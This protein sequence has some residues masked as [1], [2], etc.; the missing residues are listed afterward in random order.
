MSGSEQPQSE[1]EA[2]LEALQTLVLNNALL[3]EPQLL[4][5]REQAS[6]LGAALPL[7]HAS[8]L[9]VGCAFYQG[10]YHK[11]LNYAEEGLQLSHLHHLPLF[12]AWALSSMGLANQRLGDLSR[13][14]HFLLE[15]LKVAEQ[16]NDQLGC[17]RAMLNIGVV[18]D[19]LG[20]HD[21][22]LALHEQA[23]DAARACG[24]E[25][26]FIADA[27]YSRLEDHYKL[28][29]YA[30][31]L[32]LSAEVLAFVHEHHFSRFECNTRAVVAQ[33]LVAMGRNEAALQSV[34]A[35][36]V[37]AQ[38]C[39]D[40]ESICRLN[41]I[42][43]QILLEQGQIQKAQQVLTE[44]LRLSQ[45]LQHKS[46]ERQASA[47]LARVYEKQQQFEQAYRSLRREHELLIEQT[48]IEATWRTQQLVSKANIELNRSP[49]ITSLKE[50]GAAVAPAPPSEYVRPNVR[51]TLTGAVNRPY[52]QSRVQK[53]LELLAPEEH[54]GLLFVS[55][56]HMRSINESY[57]P[58]AGDSV[59]VEMARRLQENVRAGDLVGRVS[60]DEF[61]LLLGNLA[62]PEDLQLVMDKLL[63]VL[64]QPI[65]IAEQEF[66]ITASLGG[67]VAPED[68]QNIETLYRHADLALQQVKQTGRNAGVRFQPYMSAEEEQRRKLEF[69]LR[70]AA[71]RGEL[72]L[73][74][75]AQYDLP[76][77]RLVGYEALVRWQHP[78]LGLLG[79]GTFIPMAE[80]SHLI[81]EIG[82]WV[83]TEACRQAALWDF[84]GRDLV[85]SV[86]VSAMQFE[87]PNF[88]QRV[89]SVLEQFQLNG[90]NLA[91]ELTE[92]MVQRNQKHAVISIQEL[93]EIGVQV[94][95]DDFG[96]GYSSLS[97]LQTLPFATLKI[98]RSF[99][100]ELLQDSPSYSRALMLLEV[101][102]KLAHNLNM[103]VVAE[104][105]EYEEQFKSLCELG[106]N[107]A[108]G[109]WFTRPVPPQ[110]AE[111]L[112][113]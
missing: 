45:S 12:E 80:E 5:F 67:V 43:G 47:S 16:H 34:H 76:A 59:L 85:M 39:Q 26:S 18:H 104:G 53:T 100:S 28:G 90:E 111:K 41:S 81:G 103:H 83:L 74:Y 108:Q 96:T 69:E 9:L 79:P 60:G 93:Q 10:D 112:L 91:L 23:L 33:I 52:F 40:R 20:E 19:S 29:H 71:R 32:D 2:K 17:C 73:H 35:G 3:A 77:R 14:M 50:V 84:V 31:A 109:Y 55:V 99:L 15:S 105:I 22:A 65:R 1:M 82:D 98:D 51:D 68:G 30:E 49:V 113:D 25:A 7:T 94:A 64:R 88:V 63:G 70:G 27:L 13:A 56:D 21:M 87:Q 62:F 36:K 78:R 92:S 110:E 97:M 48:S 66:L 61:M 46:L 42:E 86:N 102:V 72:R 107:A 6:A 24:V 101:V 44:G 8:L 106:C 11:M 54:M 75:Q 58:K 89:A 57:G 4:A 38:H 95:L 37:L